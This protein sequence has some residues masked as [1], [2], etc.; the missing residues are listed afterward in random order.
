MEDIDASDNRLSTVSL[1]CLPMIKTIAEHG[2]S[3][4]SRLAFRVQPLLSLSLECQYNVRIIQKEQLQIIKISIF[5][6]VQ[7]FALVQICQWHGLS[8]D[9]SH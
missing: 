9:S 3:E 4:N 8:F 6:L 7:V 5:A 1:K 2:K